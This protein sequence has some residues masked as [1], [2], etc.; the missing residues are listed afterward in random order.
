MSLNWYVL[1]YDFIEYNE[2]KSVINQV[3]Q[4]ELIIVA[5]EYE[6]VNHP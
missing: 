3:S 5:D 1:L 4:K 6:R 2:I